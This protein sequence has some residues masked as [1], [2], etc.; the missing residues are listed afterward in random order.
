[1]HASGPYLDRFPHL[2]NERRIMA[3]G[4]AAVDDGGGA[5]SMSSTSMASATT[6]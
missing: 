4:I 6:R 3:A 2:P 5:I 1:M